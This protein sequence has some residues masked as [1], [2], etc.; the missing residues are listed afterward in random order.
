MYSCHTR[1]GKPGESQ[2]RKVT[3]LREES[4]GRRTAEDRPAMRCETQV[5]RWIPHHPRRLVDLRAIAP[6][7]SGERPLSPVS[8]VG[9]RGQEIA[10][11][12]RLSHMRH[13]AG[14]ASAASLTRGVIETVELTRRN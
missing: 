10:A 12:L 11:S 3:G 7:V 13:G 9:V 1:N 6:A 4:Y 5:V 14:E 2:R 8:A